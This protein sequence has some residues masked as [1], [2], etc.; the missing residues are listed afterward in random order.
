MSKKLNACITY[1]SS[2]KPCISLSIQ[3]LWDNFN[4]K[5]DY[6]VYVHYFDD[7]YDDEEFREEVRSKTSQNVHFISIPYETPSFLKEEEL[8]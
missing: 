6:P 3:S 1:I 5:Y 2:R 4:H 7:I 8:F